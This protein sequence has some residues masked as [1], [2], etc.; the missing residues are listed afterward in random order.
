MKKNN[1]YIWISLIILVFGIY[2][3]PKIVDRF[4]NASVVENDRLNVANRKEL[5]V[6]GKAPAFS[7]TNQ[8][9]ETITNA[10]Y[11]GKVYLV[12]F[13]FSNCP[14]ICPIMNENMVKLQNE[15]QMNANFGIV[16]I[17][18]DPENDTPEHL[19]KHAEFLG[20]TMKNWN[21]LTG[22]EDAVFDLSKKFNLYVGKNDDAPGGFEHSGLFALID[23]KGNIRSRNM[24]NMDYPMFY[25]D[26][27][28]DEGVQMLKED[29]KQLIKE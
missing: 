13:F 14:T 19:K 4:K 11:E 21:F 26:G 23:K 8:N 17:T 10:D 24:E 20:V 12:E 7:F 5:K 15:F 2:A 9:N 6:I 27:T 16:S 22:T 28:T 25:Y 3:V 29:I 1:S 18:I